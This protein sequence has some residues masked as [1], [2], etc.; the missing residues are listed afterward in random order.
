MLQFLRQSPRAC[1][2]YCYANWISLVDIPR[3]H[4]ER[5][6]PISISSLLCLPADRHR[7]RRRPAAAWGATV[8]C[9]RQTRQ[10]WTVRPGPPSCTLPAP[11]VWR[12]Y[13][14]VTIPVSLARTDRRHSPSSRT[15]VDPWFC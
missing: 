1:A 7:R 10:R 8:Q 3:Q 9:P 6:G 4:G 13:D 11:S 5:C 15:T 2:A 12:N 14:V